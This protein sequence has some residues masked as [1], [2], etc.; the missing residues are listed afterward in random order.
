MKTHFLSKFTCALMCAALCS[1]AYAKRTSIKDAATPIATFDD[2]KV[3]GV[4]ATY[5]PYKIDAPTNY[6]ENEASWWL[7]GSVFVGFSHDDLSENALNKDAYGLKLVNIQGADFMVST[8]TF[9]KQVTLN[10]RVSYFSGD[11]YDHEFQ[12]PDLSRTADVEI[13]GWKF[14]PGFRYRE[15]LIG[16]LDFFAGFNVGLASVDLTQKITESSGDGANYSGDQLVL[17]YNAEIGLTYRLSKHFSVFTSYNFFGMPS[18][19]SL[20]NDKNQT[21]TTNQGNTYDRK[22]KSDNL[23]YHMV[24]VGVNYHF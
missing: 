5:T 6:Q 3:Y 18:V 11:D 12:G 1:T 14:M 9:M 4:E 16:N 17:A 19:P 23:L 8:D 15:T 22:I 20:Y 7:E 24:R 2:K 13:E 10:F 21:Y